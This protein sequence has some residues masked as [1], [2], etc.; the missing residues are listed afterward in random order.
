MML[1]FNRSIDTINRKSQMKRANTTNTTHWSCAH[2]VHCPSGNYGNFAL[3]INEGFVTVFVAWVLPSDKWTCLPCSFSVPKW[4][5]L[6]LEVLVPTIRDW[7]FRADPS[8]IVSIIKVYAWCYRCADEGSWEINRRCHSQSM[9]DVVV[10]WDHWMAL[11]RPRSH[12]NALTVVNDA[13][14]MAING[15]LFV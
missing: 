8:A 11:V 15:Q 2:C 6:Y 10:G 1:C 3:C 5:C 14:C 13:I 9:S 7:W 12:L 4:R